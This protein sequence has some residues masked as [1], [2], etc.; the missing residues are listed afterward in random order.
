MPGHKVLKQTN[1]QKTQ[2]NTRKWT[3]H[4]WMFP[5]YAYVY[6]LGQVPNCTIRKNKSLVLGWAIFYFRQSYLRLLVLICA[7][8]SVCGFHVF[9]HRVISSPE[10]FFFFFIVIL[11]FLFQMCN[12]LPF[13][14]VPKQSLCFDLLFVFSWW[15]QL[16]RMWW[17]SGWVSVA[18][19]FF[20]FVTLIFTV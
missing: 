16:N 15:C 1:K 9:L 11:N 6:G 2:Q 17:T 4:C 18:Q 3:K 5:R 8:I 7:K 12:V 14:H 13:F 10:L 19:L 20:F